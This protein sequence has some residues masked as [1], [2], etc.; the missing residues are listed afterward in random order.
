MSSDQ[1]LLPGESFAAYKERVLDTKSSSFCGAKW[2][3]ATVWLNTGQTTAC[4]HPLPHQIDAN[5]VLKNPKLLSNTP[6][7]KKERAEMQ[8]GIQ[9]GGCDY[10]WRVE[11]LKANKISDRVYKSVLYT[12]QEL[13]KAYESSPEEDFDLRYLELSF[14]RTCNFACSYCNPAFSTTWAKDIKTYNGYKDIGPNGDDHYGNS[15]ANASRYS[16]DNNPY[17]KAFFKW[18]ESD[19]KRTLTHLRLTGGEPLMSKH[20]WKLLDLMSAG[21]SNVSYFA[22]NTNLNSKQS[23][24][25]KLIDKAKTIEGLHIYSSNESVGNKAEY[26]RDGLDWKMW[27]ENF[28]K[29]ADSRAFSSMHSMCTIGALSLEGLVEYLDWCLEVKR[30]SGSRDAVTF[31]LNILRFPNFQ[32]C[33]VLPL[34]LRQKFASDL[35]RWVTTNRNSDLLHNMEIEQVERLIEYLQNETNQI[36]KREQIVK[37]FKNYFTQYDK[38]R[39]KNFIETFPIIGEWYRGI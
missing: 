11:N 15:H 27:V 16:E 7:K 20:T 6:Q 31:T 9:C 3:Y 33:L 10:C 17:I 14:D 29:V 5:E 1:H 23:L 21:D 39:G 13:Q 2:Y 18:W 35:S 32:S 24:I 26:I 8:K 28:E 36:P 4:H 30:K 22:I 12:D 34:D 37:W 19:L 38:R 25:D